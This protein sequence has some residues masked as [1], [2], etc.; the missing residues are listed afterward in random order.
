MHQCIEGETPLL[1]HFA[2]MAQFI[3]S[4]W[5]FGLLSFRPAIGSYMFRRQIYGLLLGHL[6]FNQDH[7]FVQGQQRLPVEFTQ[8]VNIDGNYICFLERSPDLYCRSADRNIAKNA[9]IHLGRR[10]YFDAF[11]ND[12]A[13]MQ[14]PLTSILFL[15]VV[16]LPAFDMQQPGNLA[17][18]LAPILLRQPDQHQPQSIVIFGVWSILQGASRQT[19]HPAGPSLRRRKLLAP[20]DNGLAELPCRQALDSR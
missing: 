8:I 7:I 15:P 14:A 5:I 20:V 11:S 19:N 9:I 12:E 13:V 18:A 16:H 3:D 1:V 17:I 2:M 6:E 10:R 4:V